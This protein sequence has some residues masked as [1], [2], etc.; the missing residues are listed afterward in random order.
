MVSYDFKIKKARKVDICSYMINQ[1]LLDLSEELRNSVK[2]IQV[3]IMD[4][5]WDFQ[6]LENDLQL[7]FRHVESIE[8]NLNTRTEL[9]AQCMMRDK[10]SS[11]SNEIIALNQNME[12]E[13]VDSTVMIIMDHQFYIFAEKITINS[14]KFVKEEGDYVIWNINN[15]SVN[16][17]NKR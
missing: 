2:I 17:P 9:N 1:D 14:A 13:W 10:V 5:S 3:N 6:S 16:F 12:L 4:Y 15:S 7:Y 11:F 8:F